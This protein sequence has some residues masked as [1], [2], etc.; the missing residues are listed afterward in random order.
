MHIYTHNMS[1]VSC[2]NSTSIKADEFQRLRQAL[3]PII[4][5]FR[6]SGI[7]LQCSRPG[8]Q[9]SLGMKFRWII[10]S[11][12]MSIL[13][14]IITGTGITMNLYRIVTGNDNSDAAQRVCGIVIL[15]GVLIMHFVVLLKHKDLNQLLG[16]LFSQ[17]VPV[18]RLNRLVVGLFIASYSLSIIICLSY[19]NF[20]RDIEVDGQ[21]LAN[22]TGWGEV[23]FIDSTL[24]DVFEIGVPVFTGLFII[25]FYFLTIGIF[26]ICCCVI[27]HNFSKLLFK[28]SKEIY[29][30]QVNISDP[31]ELAVFEIQS[32]E[33]KMGWTYLSEQVNMFFRR[34]QIICHL[35][36]LTNSAFGIMCFIW[37]SAEVIAIVLAVRSMNLTNSSKIRYQLLAV[38]IASITCFIARSVYAARVNS[39]VLDSLK[40]L[41]IL[42][43]VYANSFSINAIAI[44]SGIN[45]YVL[46]MSVSAPS[47]TGWGFFNVDKGLILTVG[48]TVVTYVLVLYQD[49]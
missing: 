45:S 34:H 17:S 4:F 1:Q 19:I 47:I 29:C 37:C 23:L 39:L 42:S 30:R 40:N 10:Q 49:S 11:T 36:D 26:L 38:F 46:N 31:E 6:L 35:V 12:V 2:A 9:M 3:K 16:L 15:L 48:G 14:F 20:G 22:F 32:P 13:A 7:P 25:P 27:E 43:E 5:A 33:T 21:E 8:K 28:C 18:P 44:Q 24:N 41:R